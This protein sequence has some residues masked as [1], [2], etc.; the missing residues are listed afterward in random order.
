MFI[1]N[2][3]I[4]YKN[5]K[6]RKARVFLT[7][8]GI[9]I[10]IMA[11]VSLMGI[12]QG[13]QQAIS[14]ELSSLSDTIIVFGGEIN[15]GMGGGG[16]VD[17]GNTFLDRDI[18]SIQRIDGIRDISPVYFGQALVT[19][20]GLTKPVSL[21]GMDP[22]NMQN[23]F[24]IETLGLA[25]GSFM[26]EGEQF[27]CVVGHQ[28]AYNMFDTDMNVGARI[29]I[30]DNNFVVN[31]IYKRQGAG[32][33]VPTDDNIHLS[34][35]DFKKI[36]GIRDISGIIIRV[37]DVA[38]VERIADEIEQV[39]NQNHGSDDFAKA[40]TMASIL[41]SI[42]SVLGIVQMVLIAIASIALIVASIGI[43]NTMLTSVME[44][45]H[46]IGIMKAIGA[47]NTDVMTIFIVEGLLISLIGGIAGIVLGFIGARGFTLFSAGFLGGGMLNPVITLFS[48][49]LAVSV[50]MFVGILSS[51]YPAWKAAKM[52]PIEA[53]RYE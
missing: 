47:R 15:A 28:I 33:S 13:M 6:Q 14:G 40:T 42:Q 5:I 4:A 25:E 12:G 51:L 31:G 10:G 19:Y 52:S 9:A 16:F 53:V 34:S 44:R 27:K 43:M 46:E 29:R 39:I 22:D 21:L 41:E 48:I 24:G 7:L 35:H 38:N 23:I 45:T 37:Y 49:I 18:D 50:S 11:I 30:N 17:N 1:D 26:D 3:L 36:T 2:F 32:F 8:L 20:N